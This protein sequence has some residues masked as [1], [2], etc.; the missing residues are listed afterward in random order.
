MHIDAA[1]RISYVIE[2]ALKKEFPEITDVV[3]HM[4]PK[5]KN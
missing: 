1:H 2:G 5:E 4:E 3:V